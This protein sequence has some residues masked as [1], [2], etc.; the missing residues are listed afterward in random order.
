MGRSLG[1]VMIVLSLVISAILLVAQLTGTGGSGPVGGKLDK[2]APVERA[3]TEA[4]TVAA[5]EAD[6][7]LQ[8]Y[9]IDHGTFVGAQV[10]DVSGVSVRR[11]DTA[12]YCLQIVTNGVALYEA[13]PG[14]SLSPQPCG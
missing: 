14:G 5:F 6:R 8:A 2:N 12:S 4:A 7:E 3:N 11:A 13:G 1:L 9:Q 10:T